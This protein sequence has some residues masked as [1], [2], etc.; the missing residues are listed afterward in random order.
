M[1]VLD[2][3]VLSEPLKP[4]PNRQVLEWLDR[5]VVETLSTTAITL[6]ELLSGVARLP[7]GIRKRRL[8]SDIE[9]TMQSLFGQR[10]LPFDVEA[11]IAYAQ[12]ETLT[13]KN[14]QPLSVAD[15]QIAAIAKSRHYA[16][17]TRDVDPFRAAGVAVINP[18]AP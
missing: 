9:Q 16:V 10:I 8:A 18:W 13:R 17:A 12:I 14:G 3:C 15:Q 1:I 4:S 2:T 11:A 7:D 5:Q 6:A